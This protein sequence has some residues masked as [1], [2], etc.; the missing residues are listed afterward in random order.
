MF[1]SPKIFNVLLTFISRI[2]ESYLVNLFLFFKLGDD[3]TNF[4]I[5]DSYNVRNRKS[6]IMLSNPQFIRTIYFI[7][8]NLLSDLI[9]KQF[10][11]RF[12]F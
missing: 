1:A 10:P 3:R 8:C 2:S 5:E 4:S 11:L 7:K 12:N 6:I 9:L